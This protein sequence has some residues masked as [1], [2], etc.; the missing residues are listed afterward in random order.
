MS[1]Y[2]LG[3]NHQTAPVALRERVAFGPDTLPPAL[4][5]L[6]GLPGVHEAVLLSTCNRTEL[7]AHADGDGTRL[8]P[9]GFALVGFARPQI[10]KNQHRARAQILETHGSSLL[11]A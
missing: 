4:D 7:Y 5:A 1:L 10:R 11:A 2:V 3:I 9:F 8:A 6:R